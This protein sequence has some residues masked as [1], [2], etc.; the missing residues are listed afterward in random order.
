[1]NSAPS[2][3][4]AVS[5][6]DD[7]PTAK[8]RRPIRSTHTTRRQR[9]ED[10][11][12]WWSNARSNIGWGGLA[13]VAAGVL[14]VVGLGGTL[15]HGLL[16]DG[17]SINP[18]SMLAQD[19]DTEASEGGRVAGALDSGAPKSVVV[20]T[21]T[22]YQPS[23]LEGQV[24]ALVDKVHVTGATRSTVAEGGKPADA[25]QD[26]VA[27]GDL[28]AGAWSAAELAQCLKAIDAEDLSP[29]A[30]DF[31]R[32]N[33]REVALLVL[34]SPSKEYEVWAVSRSCKPGADGTQFFQIVKP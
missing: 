34:P 1:V 3:D 9:K 33:G 8:L 7:R 13:A 11:G 30:V 22:N 2:V 19:Q 4:S 14:V 24:R 28:P 23:K 21:D 5:D 16:P 32:F 25:N 6:E 31:A 12:G 20:S 27:G 18:A 29:V 26:S 17:S 15:I 10:H